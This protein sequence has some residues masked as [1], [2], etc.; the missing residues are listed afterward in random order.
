M[1]GRIVVLLNSQYIIKQTSLFKTRA[2]THTHTR[3]GPLFF[4][5]E[6][7]V[8]PLRHFSKELDKSLRVSHLL[9]NFLILNKPVHNTSGPV[10]LRG[11][12]DRQH[13]VLVLFHEITFYNPHLEQV[14][15]PIHSFYYVLRHLW[16]SICTN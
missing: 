15:L 9:T 13:K 1:D 6:M 5:Q 10:M 2:N 7:F 14:L 3:R 16:L 8:D 4:G 12:L 11:R